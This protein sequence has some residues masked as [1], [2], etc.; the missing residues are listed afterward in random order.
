VL[1][2]LAQGSMGVIYRARDSI[3]DREVALK[4]I[5]GT[6]SVDPELKERF[7]REARAGARLQHR[8]VITI[9]D[10]GEQDGLVFIALELLSGCDLRQLIA[11]RRTLPVAGKI[12]IMAA[13]CD[14]L[15]HAH[16]H[17]IVHRDIKPSNV[18]LTDEGVP[19][20]LD[21]GVARLAA[22]NLTVIGRVLGTPFYMSPEQIMGESCDARSDLFA[23]ALV[24]Y[25]LLAYAHPFAGASIP[26]RIMHDPPDSLLGH[27]PKLPAALEQILNKA[28]SKDPAGRYQTAEKFGQAL[29]GVLRESAAAPESESELS[30]VPEDARTEVKMSAVLTALEGFNDAIE[31][32]NV[33][34]ARAALAIVEELARVDDRFVIAAR[35]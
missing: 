29:R 8:N 14:G 3:L 15:H 13:V 28:L 16:C 1:G 7:Y 35:E 23:L 2:E 34:K 30:A 12:E 24:T 22:S 20:I 19:K 6:G 18:F 33:K 21:F 25:E 31:V 17:G 4:T 26:K 5:A 11:S 27:D 32:G 10:L 9:Y